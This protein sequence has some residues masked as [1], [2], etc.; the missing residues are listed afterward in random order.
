MAPSFTGRR[1][2]HLTASRE[3]TRIESDAQA[4][5]QPMQDFAIQW[6]VLAGWHANFAAA[7]LRG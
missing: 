7:G 1:R 5:C 2:L 3:L 6:P 4:A